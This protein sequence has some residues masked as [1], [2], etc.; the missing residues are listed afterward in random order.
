MLR[1]RSWTTTFQLWTTKQ[2]NKAVKSCLQSGSIGIQ[3]FLSQLLSFLQ[4]DKQKTIRISLKVC[5]HTFDK[6]WQALMI[7][8]Y[9]GPYRIQISPKI[10]YTFSYQKLPINSIIRV[11]LLDFNFSLSS[12]PLCRCASEDLLEK[13]NRL[14]SHTSSFAPFVSPVTDTRNRLIFGMHVNFCT[15]QTVSGQLPILWRP[16]HD[17][18]SS[19]KYV[20][21]TTSAAMF[22]QCWRPLNGFALSKSTS[23]FGPGIL[24]NYP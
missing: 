4:E 5:Y 11:I 3:S 6:S 18:W 8:I 14:R 12:G 10:L 15:F 20:S 7:I 23:L 2:G 17:H 9:S 21:G 1:R 19:R 22:M 13:N 16:S 24:A